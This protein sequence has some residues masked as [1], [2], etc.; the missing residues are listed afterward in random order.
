MS[1]RIYPFGSPMEY[2][3]SL[4]KIEQ[5]LSD[6]LNNRVVVFYI[7]N[8]QDL[9]ICVGAGKNIRS[10][11]YS[12]PMNGIPYDDLLEELRGIAFLMNMLA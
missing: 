12:I 8:H 2:R 10:R 6:E 7:H 9:T 4:N 11:D 3:R 1:E 5:E